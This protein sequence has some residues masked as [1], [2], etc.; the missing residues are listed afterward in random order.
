M[1]N[2][3]PTNQPIGLDIGSSR[4]VAAR[5]VD[6]RYH[7]DSQLNSFLTVPYSRLTASLLERDKVFHEVQGAEILLTSD[8]AHRFAE[9]FHVEMR[10]PM[11]NGVLNPRE[12]HSL[13]VI[14]RIIT[15]LIGKAASAG[16]SVFFSVPAPSVAGDDGIAYHRASISQILTELGYQ[17]TAFEEGLAVV[18]GEMAASNFSGIGISCGSGMC[19]VCLAVLSLPVISFSVAKAG[20]FIDSRRRW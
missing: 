19:N 7:Y 12:P 9:V 5:T 20:D 14:R 10:R 1:N 18:F 15:R 8:D 16:Q 3:E 11:L 6:K 2:T 17:P 13:A 4:I